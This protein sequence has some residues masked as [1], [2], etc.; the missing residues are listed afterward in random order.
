MIVQYISWCSQ[1]QETMALSSCGAEFM[2]ATEVAKQDIW[3]QGL[4]E[5]VTEKTSRKVAI[6]IDN[7]STIAFT[8]N[9][10][11][12]GRIKYIRKRYHF[13]H[14]CIENEQVDVQHILRTE[15]KA[16]I[17]TKV[18]GRIKFNEMREFVGI[19]D[20]VSGRSSKIF[21]WRHNTNTNK[22]HI[23]LKALFI[24]IH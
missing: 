5:E 2:T 24:F 20:V 16:D 12:Y 7:K 22:K 4:L 14:E 1:K 23:E 19:Q 13:I 9:H 3:L 8:K 17:L 11:F 15:Q 6:R 21:S 10:V 18:L